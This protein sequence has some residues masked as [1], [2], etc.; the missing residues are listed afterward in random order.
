MK[1]PHRFTLHGE[2][3]FAFAG[4]WESGD[5]AMPETFGIL[6][7]KPNDLVGRG[8]DPMGE[9]AGSS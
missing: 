4:I 9:G 5:A 3:P 2:E 6:T 7:T 1:L 8:H